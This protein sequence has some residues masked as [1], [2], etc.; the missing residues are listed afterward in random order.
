[1]V[2]RVVRTKYGADR[3]REHM[4]RVTESITALAV[5]LLL[6]GCAGSDPAT[7]AVE[8]GL[9]SDGPSGT[10]EGRVVD[11]Q[12]L[13]LQGVEVGIPA[14]DRK[15]V[16]AVD[17]SFR[18]FGIAPG[19]AEIVA[20]KA[21]YTT[22]RVPVVV[23][24]DGVVE[25]LEIVLAPVAVP[26]AAFTQVFPGH[27]FLGCGF[28]TGASTL[29]NVRICEAD[30]NTNQFFGFEVNRSMGLVVLVLELAWTPTA[31]GTAT[32]M[33]EE[34]WK[35]NCADCADVRYQYGGEGDSHLSGTSPIQMVFGSAAAP[36][37]DSLN[38]V[39]PTRLL[40]FAHVSRDTDP[41]VV[42]AVQQPVDFYVSAF[43]N[44]APGPDYTQVP[45]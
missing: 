33:R 36:F 41:V 12:F 20:T 30:P 38:D 35:T 29:S 7:P 21:G 27:G 16:T 14:I 15:V 19:S 11:D 9:T 32:H 24:A 42:V 22:S 40:V 45:S 31:P 17:G 37:A 25:D 2:Q 4:G 5:A 28:K 13:A 34:L 10:V 23:E 6:A 26:K 43:Y 3:L 1:M 18:L 8:A 39:G 44:S